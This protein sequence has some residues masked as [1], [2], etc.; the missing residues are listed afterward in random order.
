MKPDEM[1]D[2]RQSESDFTTHM[3]A[4]VNRRI[5]GHTAINET[6]VTETMR[7]MDALRDKKRWTGV[8][9]SDL[10]GTIVPII[11]DGEETGSS[12]ADRR[13]PAEYCSQMAAARP[14]DTGIPMATD[15]QL[16]DHDPWNALCVTTMPSTASTVVAQIHRQ[17]RALKLSVTEHTN[18]QAF[19]DA[20]G[21]V[22]LIR[23]EDDCFLFGLYADYGVTCRMHTDTF[24]LTHYC[25]TVAPGRS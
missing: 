7:M 6:Q 18:L 3:R 12:D 15:A 25:F 14:N 11:A 22:Q 17:L 23:Q 5:N 13:T 21:V 9:I 24:V 2:W 10:S 20:S 1:D 8:H 19:A 16:S 4:A